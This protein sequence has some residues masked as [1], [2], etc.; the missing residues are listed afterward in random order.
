MR[1]TS[2]FALSLL[3]VLMT[4]CGTI[5]T[6]PEIV[7]PVDAAR[8]ERGVEVYRA[9]Y[10]GACHTLTAANTRGTF[11]P[12]HD[13][14]YTLAAAHLTLRAYTGSA[15]DVEAYLRESILEPTV[16]YTP[17]YEATN[18]HMPSFAHLPP[19][20]IDALVYLLMSQHGG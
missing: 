14:A 15:E 9:N 16:F 12:G 1:H 5:A 20:D 19:E 11:G 3:I 7:E 13:D 18:H 10:C 17:G 8:V 6:P 2:L 4:A